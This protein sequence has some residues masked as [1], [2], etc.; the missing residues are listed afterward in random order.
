MDGAIAFRDASHAKRPLA[1]AAAYAA[2]SSTL[3]VETMVKMCGLGRTSHYN[4]ADREVRHQLL[5]FLSPRRFGRRL[6][7]RRR[8]EQSVRLLE[9]RKV[10]PRG[11]PFAPAVQARSHREHHVGGHG[12]QRPV[13]GLGP[14]SRASWMQLPQLVDGRFEVLVGLFLVGALLL[15]HRA[16][17]RC[18]DVLV[19]SPLV[20]AVWPHLV[21]EP[22]L[23][24][25]RRREVARGRY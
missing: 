20:V 12:H 15:G 10:R 23:R 14:R 18:H 2:L 24:A 4:P 8:R 6:G 17:D 3:A 19:P 7:D 13:L 16:A 11:L 9:A 5:R 22:R 25:R 21:V 1:L